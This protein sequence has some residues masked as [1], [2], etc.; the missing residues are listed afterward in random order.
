MSLSIMMFRKFQYCWRKYKF[1]TYFLT[2][3]ITYLTDFYTSCIG[4]CEITYLTSFIKGCK[5]L[6]SIV[7][8][9]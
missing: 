2:Y 8:K 9:L 7:V 3:L 1:K 6:R 5:C 4:M